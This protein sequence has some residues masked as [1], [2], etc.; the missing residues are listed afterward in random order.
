MSVFGYGS[1]TVDIYKDIKGTVSVRLTPEKEVLIGGKIEAKELKPFGEGFNY[2]KEILAFP[3]LEFP[4]AGIP[5]ISVSAFITGGVHFKFIW[6]PLVLKE[7]S[8]DFKETNINELEKASLEIIGSVGSSAHAEVYLFIKAGLKARVLVAT[9]KGSLGGEAGLGVD[10][11]A[12]G[13]VDAVWDME[14]GLKF[15][16]IKAFLDVTPKAIFR[17]TGDVSVDLDLWVTTINLY[18]HKWVLAEKQLDLS[19]IT[20]KVEFPIKF[21]ET[22]EV[23]LP[24][25]ES[26]TIVK[27]DFSGDSGNKILDDAINGDAR[28]EEQKKKEELKIKIHDDLRSADNKDVTPTEYTRKMMAKYKNAPELQ[29]FVRTTIEEESR[30][31]EYEHFEEQKSIIRN[32]NVPLTNKY[33]MLNMFTLFHAYVTP[34]DVESFKAELAKIEEEKT[35]SAANAAKTGGSQVSDNKPVND[36]PGPPNTTP[37]PLNNNVSP[38]R[39]KEMADKTGKPDVQE[40]QAIQR[41][42]GFESEKEELISGKMENGTSADNAEDS[43]YENLDTAKRNGEHMPDS[44]REKMEASLG[45]DFSN[46]RIH[47]D[48]ES[49]KLS[50]QINAQAFT[51]GNDIF[52]NAGKYD[53]SS[54]QGQ[55]LLAHEL[56]H[57]LQQGAAGMDFKKYPELSYIQ[58]RFL[59]IQ[60]EVNEL[61]ALNAAAILRKSDAV[62]QMLEM[63]NFSSLS[64]IAKYFNIDLPDDPVAAVEKVLDV[65][66][67]PYVRPFISVLPGFDSLILS[68]QITLKMYRF[69]EYIIKNKEK[70]IGEFKSYLENKLDQLEPT[71]KATLKSA[72]GF[73]DH[74][75]FVAVWEA[76]LLPMLKHLKDNWW[77]TIKE[78]LWEQIWPFEGISSVTAKNPA[79]RIGLGK[80]LNDIKDHFSEGWD[81]MKKMNFSKFL[82]NSLLVAKDLTGLVNR[83]YGW[84]AIIIIASETLAGAGI[85]GVFSGGTLSGPG[86]AAGFGAGLATAGSIG[87]ALLIAT[88]AVDASILG[89]SILSLNDFDSMLVDE[90]ILRE[91]N[92]YYKRIAQTSISLTLTGLLFALA[93]LGG[94]IAQALLSKLIKFLPASLQ[95]VMQN[96]K[97]GMLGEKPGAVAD[98]NLQ[99][100]KNP[101]ELNAE[102]TQLRERV[103]NPD[104]IK[105]VTDPELIKDYD[106]QVKAGDHI[107]RRNR[108]NGSWCRYSEGICGFKLEDVNAEIDKAL[109]IKGPKELAV[110]ESL[111]VPYKKGIARA[112]VIGIDDKFIKIKI[113]S[114]SASGDIIQTMPIEDFNNLLK[115]GKIIRWTQER[116]MLMKNRPK[117]DDGLVEKVWDT[118]KNGDGKVLDPHTKEELTW[119]KSKSRTD[120]WHMGHK[121]GKEYTKLVD[122]FVN[123]KITYEEFIKEYNNPQ[124]YWPESPAEN[125]SHKHEA[126]PVQKKLLIT[127]TSLQLEPADAKAVDY[128]PVLNEAFLRR[129][130]NFF[131]DLLHMGRKPGKEYA[132]L[133][134]EYLDGKIDFEEF[135]RELT[136]LSNYWLEDPVESFSD[137]GEE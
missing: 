3:E 108:L 24:T 23:E 39:K 51:Y 133:V 73:V 61:N 118:A 120:Q 27:P 36:I 126:K 4:L 84:A 90:G 10:A 91:N 111:S 20:L 104:N 5:G 31:L 137:R 50:K 12:G 48:V 105:E 64:G 63:P 35:M 55:H 60:R 87:E 44:I 8:L 94:K 132:K 97:R 93:Y 37:P 30:K 66:Q 59:Q 115:D 127:G 15:K 67:K 62:V 95:E 102:Y 128:S 65:L 123:G 72:F 70:I 75:H 110:G 116:E 69:I 71:L 119:D 130:T 100:K 25:Y 29:A 33:S 53:T 74:R 112:E 28:K 86:A 89:K 14:K 114:K 41:N 49:H 56:T 22:G 77:E 96:I 121:P 98:D 80:D 125:I 135:L 82:D 42:Q 76:H 13:K 45:A 107:Y 79:D 92:E 21:K 122:E 19:G 113:K 103:K 78:T 47:N 17:L 46:V 99:V 124:N 136:D 109:K 101:P 7:M 6:L 83:F 16:E 43:F 131:T 1:L 117:Y 52:F 18:Y 32:A 34:A 11:E 88:V 57:I 26:M 106:V 58:A 85:A 38:V 2:D 54:I 9:L 68:L 40:R 134:G 129:R 81:E